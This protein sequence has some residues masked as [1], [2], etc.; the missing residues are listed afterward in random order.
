MTFNEDSRVKLPAIFHLCRLGYDFVLTKKN[1]KMTALRNWLLPMLMNGQ[2][3]VGDEVDEEMI[4]MA[5]ERMEEYKVR[6]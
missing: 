3:K 4:G 5:A 1:Q 6:E 2:V